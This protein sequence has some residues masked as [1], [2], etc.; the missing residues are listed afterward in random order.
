MA[1]ATAMGWATG[2]VMDRYGTAPPKPVLPRGS[3]GQCG[4]E[5]VFGAELG[6]ELGVGESHGMF[7][8]YSTNTADGDVFFVQHVS[9][10]RNTG[11]FEGVSWP[12]NNPA[13]PLGG[14]DQTELNILTKPIKY[15]PES[16]MVCWKIWCSHSNILNPSISLGIFMDF[17]PEGLVL[18][19][20]SREE[21][22]SSRSGELVC[23]KCRQKY[24]PRYKSEFKDWEFLRQFSGWD[25]DYITLGWFIYIYIF[26][27]D[28][29]YV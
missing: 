26:I 9:S 3:G 2:K 18:G 5:L 13:S 6:M 15:P 8:S 24:D 1:A 23:R 28:D 11:G 14:H 29:I 7:E 12:I 19:L 25:V 21:H 4:R 17:P 22:R 16:D 20:W 10:C 27:Y